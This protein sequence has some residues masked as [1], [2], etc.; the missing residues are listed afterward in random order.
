M[1][2]T[3]RAGVI[4]MIGWCMVLLAGL[5]HLPMK[6]IAVIGIAIIAGH[7]ITNYLGGLGDAA[8]GD[9]YIVFN[10]APKL[11]RLREQYPVLYQARRV[12]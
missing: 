11:E 8:F 9:P 5:I 1:R 7:N 10:D 2:T 12:P 4:W 3:S 6:A